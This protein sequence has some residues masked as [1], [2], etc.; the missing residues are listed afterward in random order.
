MTGPLTNPVYS[1]LPK[2]G[3]TNKT[4]KMIT[5]CAYVSLFVW[6]KPKRHVKS[7]GV[8]ATAHL[9]ACAGRKKTTTPI[10]SRED[11]GSRGRKLEVFVLT[12]GVG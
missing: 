2:T 4:D 6:F 1:W 10:C 9:H 8:P 3:T 12:D 5:A 11:E 7:Y